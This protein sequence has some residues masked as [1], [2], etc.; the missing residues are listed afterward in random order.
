[1]GHGELVARQLIGIA[2]GAAGPVPTAPERDGETCLVL[3]DPD[4]VA[5]RVSDERE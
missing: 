5:L 3:H 1:M 2:G 4:D